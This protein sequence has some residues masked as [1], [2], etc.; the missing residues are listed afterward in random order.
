[1]LIRG[2]RILQQL[3]ETT[4]AELER[5]TA[6]FQPPS[7]KRQHATDPIRVTQMQ[8][9]PF[10][11]QRDTG[12]LKVEAIAQSGGKKYSPILYF[13]DVVFEEADQADNVSFTAGDGDVYHISPIQ[14]SRSNVKV[15]CD[16]L[17]FYFRFGSRNRGDDS[18]Y[19]APLPPYKRK[20]TTHASANPN[21]VPG[22]CKHLIKVVQALGEADLVTR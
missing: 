10:R 6:N 8:L 14:L 18:L 16:C 13:S 11:S 22:L 17:D 19:G 1:M 21:N 5:S 9:I 3:E 7:R 20:T 4:Y 12:D 15:R 2:P